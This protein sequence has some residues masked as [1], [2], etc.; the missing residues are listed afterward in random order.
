VFLRN[1]YNSLELCPRTERA[2]ANAEVE[3]NWNSL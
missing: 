1:I 3:V 2:K